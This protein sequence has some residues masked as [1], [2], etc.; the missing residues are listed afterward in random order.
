MMLKHV[1]M[2]SEP[3]NKWFGR[4]IRSFLKEQKVLPDIPKEGRIPFKIYD[5]DEKEHL[6]ELDEYRRIYCRSWFRKFKPKKGDEIEIRVEKNKIIVQP[7]TT[8][9]NISKLVAD[10]KGMEQDNTNKRNI[11]QIIL[12]GPPGTGKTY[13]TKKFALEITLNMKEAHSENKGIDERRLPVFETFKEWLIKYPSDKLIYTKPQRKPYKVSFENNK[14][15]FTPLSD[16]SKGSRYEPVHSLEKVFKKFIERK[17]EITSPY[18][19]DSFNVSY[20]LPL[21]EI[22]IEETKTSIER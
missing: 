22:F 7:M 5:N 8:S 1:L 12:Y 2:L 10:T 4:E 19:N 14:F 11:K 21:I 16:D 13:Y 9:D 17:D 3:T 18:K 6:A 20:I 15:V